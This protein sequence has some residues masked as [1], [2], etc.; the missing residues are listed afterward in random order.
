MGQEI[1]FWVLAVVAIA[2]AIG[3]VTIR[4]VFRTAM[5]LVACFVAIAGVFILLNADFLAAIQV[6]IYVGAVSILIVL[7]VMLTQEITRASTSNKLQIPTLLLVGVSLAGF[8]YAIFNT[9][10]QLS[11]ATPDTSTTTAIANRIFGENGLI[12][13]LQVIPVLLMATV[14]IAMVL[15][16]VKKK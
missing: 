1:S 9:D 7:G 3:V 2:A 16:K 12:L 10:W 8:I 14:I 5:S 11:S 6:L 4:N 15:V 13:P